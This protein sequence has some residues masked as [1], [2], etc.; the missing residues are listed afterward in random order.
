MK[1]GTDI[2]VVAARLYFL[3]IRARVPLK[4]GPETVTEVTCARVCVRI[5]SRNGRT[6]EGWGETPLSVTWV[7]PSQLSY[8]ARYERLK[9]FCLL[10]AEAWTDFAG[11]GHPIEIGN[12][13]QEQVL[14]SLARKIN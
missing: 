6:A 3:P 9:Q 1:K 12:E 5:C 13:F 7:W 14:P 4:F 11:Q 10:L 8:S 2:R